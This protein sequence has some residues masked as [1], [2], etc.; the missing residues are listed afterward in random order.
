MKI[1]HNRFLSL[2]LLLACGL[3]MNA[4][5]QNQGTPMLVMPQ[6]GPPMQMQIEMRTM[7]PKMGEQHMGHMQA[8]QAEHHA[9][10][11]QELKVFL[12]LQTGQE[13]AW[14]TFA[15]AFQ[16]PMTR[17]APLNHDEM[18]KLSTPERIDKM[19]AMKAAR[20]AQINTRMSA[21]KTF[22]ATL[23]PQQQKVFDAHASKA[24]KQRGMGFEHGGHHG[25][26]LGK[27][28]P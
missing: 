28:H 20:D 1:K 16:N 14:A 7:N 15:S 26:G 3:S 10:R 23:N 5:A 19:M 2:G 6:G 25:G 11:L 21:T 17:P 8:I 22:Y 13:A 9:K 12:Q 27:M 18:E 4:F 24:M